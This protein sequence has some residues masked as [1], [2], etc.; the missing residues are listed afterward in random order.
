MRTFRGPRDRPPPRL[1]FRH[2]RLRGGRLARLRAALSRAGRQDARVQA[3]AAA[4]GDGARRRS[5]AAF[6]RRRSEALVRRSR[7]VARLRVGRPARLFSFTRAVRAVAA[8][9]PAAVHW[10]ARDCYCYGIHCTAAR[11]RAADSC[12]SFAKRTDSVVP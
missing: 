1:R 4:R 2:V 6:R 9:N 8:S 7:A 3:G 12:S 5:L 11:R 10:Y